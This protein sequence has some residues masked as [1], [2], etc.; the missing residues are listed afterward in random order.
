MEKGA[1]AHSI[2]MKYM[3]ETAQNSQKKKRRKKSL[4]DDLNPDL[5][6]TR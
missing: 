4:D 2:R 1:S 5:S 3:S 6:P